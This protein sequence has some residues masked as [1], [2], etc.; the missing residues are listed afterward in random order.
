M[1]QWW[2]VTWYR[3]SSKGHILPPHF[4]RYLILRNAW[5]EKKIRKGKKKKVICGWY[6]LQRSVTYILRKIDSCVVRADPSRYRI[7]IRWRS[8]LF[9]WFQ[10]LEFHG[11]WFVLMCF[12]FSNK[13]FAFLCENK[14]WIIISIIH[15]IVVPLVPLWRNKW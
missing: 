9:L 12:L 4:C 2:R 11:I 7:Q 3:P 8:V 6:C 13:T 5:K 1:D 10:M 14:S 15:C